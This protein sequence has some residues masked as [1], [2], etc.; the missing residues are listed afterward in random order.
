MEWILL[1]RYTNSCIVFWKP[2]IHFGF[3]EQRGISWR[4]RTSAISWMSVLREVGTLKNCSKIVVPEWLWRFVKSPI[5]LCTRKQITVVPV[6]SLALS[7]IVQERFGLLL[8]SLHFLPAL[9]GTT[10]FL[11]GVYPIIFSLHYER[12]LTPYYVSMTLHTSW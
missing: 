2:F 6:H 1:G 11:S 7:S 8:L 10:K 3:C 9:P 4:V 12:Q 5:S